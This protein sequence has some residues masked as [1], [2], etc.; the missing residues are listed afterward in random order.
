MNRFKYQAYRQEFPFLIDIIADEFN[1]IP[2]SVRVKRTDE[3]LLKIIPRYYHH[4]GSMGQTEQDE[5]VHFVLTDGSIIHDAVNRS[6]HT[7]SSYAHFQTREWEGETVLEAIDRH[8][9]AEN[10][11]FIVHDVFNLDD[12]EGQTYYR[13]WEIVIYK[14]P[15]GTSFGAEIE[16]ARARALVEVRAEAGF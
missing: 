4:D 14:T 6:G 3:N 16:K 7:S 2:D 5:R 13:S 12:W 1:L 9:V 8:G 10:L 11:A 15:K